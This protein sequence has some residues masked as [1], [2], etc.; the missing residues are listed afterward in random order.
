LTAIAKKSS[1][2]P[3]VKFDRKRMKKAL[4]AKQIE[5]SPGL[6]REEKRALILATSFNSTTHHN[7]SQLPV[8]F[9]HTFSLG[10][11]RQ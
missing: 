8:C 10:D 2:K 9:N 6:S 4:K 3:N 1:E 7:F 5:V 11:Q